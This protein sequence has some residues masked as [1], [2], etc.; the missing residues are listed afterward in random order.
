[1]MYADLDSDI[2][3]KIDMDYWLEKYY[4]IYGLYTA[5]IDYKAALVTIKLYGTTTREIKIGQRRVISCEQYDD[6]SGRHQPIYYD[7]ELL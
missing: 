3:D 6:I 5:E 1:M 7:N 2:T 4:K